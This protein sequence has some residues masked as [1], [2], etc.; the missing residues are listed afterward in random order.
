MYK[1]QFA[2][3]ELKGFH[4]MEIDFTTLVGT[5]GEFIKI[6]LNIYSE[7]LQNKTTRVRQRVCS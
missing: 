5:N 6:Q 7:R 3:S 4:V 1:V 2:C